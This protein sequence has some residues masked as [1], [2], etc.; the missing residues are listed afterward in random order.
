MELFVKVGVR[1][2][3]GGGGIPAFL[4]MKNS[5]K[6]PV[7]INIWKRF[8]HAKVVSVDLLTASTAGMERIL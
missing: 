7:I 2:K 5:P 4:K 8:R 1:L 6:T 3:E